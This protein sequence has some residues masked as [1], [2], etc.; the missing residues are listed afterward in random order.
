MCYAAQH[1]RLEIV[2]I[3]APLMKNPNSLPNFFGF[4]PIFLAS[5]YGHLEIIKFLAPLSD[6]LT[7]E[8]IKDA[9]KIAQLYGHHH[10]ARYFSSR[11][12]S[13][14]PLNH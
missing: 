14:S 11:R 5:T 8:A 6:H 2:K 12:T 4:T 1:G 7:Y 10:V 3:L 13:S 9:R